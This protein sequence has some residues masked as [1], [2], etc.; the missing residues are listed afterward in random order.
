MADGASAYAIPLFCVM[1]GDEA[2]RAARASDVS[3][4]AA[5]PNAGPTAFIGRAFI[6]KAELRKT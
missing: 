3:F 4:D 1:M 5:E 6:R 2:S